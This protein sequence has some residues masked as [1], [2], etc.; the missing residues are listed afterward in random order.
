MRAG[1]GG[2]SVGAAGFSSGV[3]GWVAVR[4]GGSAGGADGMDFGCHFLRSGVGAIGVAVAVGFSVRIVVVSRVRDVS[5]FGSEDW[6]GDLGC[7]FLRSTDG[8]AVGGIVS[9]GRT[10]MTGVVIDEGAVMG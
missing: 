2:S 1:G 5:G 7:H 6:A 8:V 3:L 10:S 4:G 9:T